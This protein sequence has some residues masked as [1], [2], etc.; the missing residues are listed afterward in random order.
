MGLCKV[1]RP[2]VKVGHGTPTTFFAPLRAAMC[3]PRARMPAPGA[4][5]PAESPPGRRQ[6]GS[7]AAAT[8]LKGGPRNGAPASPPRGGGGDAQGPGHL[9]RP[10]FLAF[11]LRRALSGAPLPC[12]G[13]PAR[14]T[15]DPGR[16]LRRGTG[17]RSAGACICAAPAICS[18]NTTARAASADRELPPRPKAGVHPCQKRAGRFLSIPPL[19]ANDGVRPGTG[20]RQRRA[21]FVRLQACV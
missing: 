11:S 17:P 10:G 2:V 19:Q 9:T 4:P 15:G 13:R 14:A 3:R 5:G 12:L 18:R 7:A 6:P 8:R 16:S 20:T 21:Q 1:Q